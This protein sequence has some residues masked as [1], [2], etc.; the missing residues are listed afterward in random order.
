MDDV[1]RLSIFQPYFTTKPAG[2][3]TGLGLWIVR[4]IVERCAG[5]ID[6]RTSVGQGTSFV[7]YFPDEVDGGGNPHRRDG[8]LAVGAR[9]M[10]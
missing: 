5:A 1:T 4:D 8:E 9:R 3:G 6:V 10:Q 2:H 7:I